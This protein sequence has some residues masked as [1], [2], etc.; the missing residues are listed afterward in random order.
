[1]V[2]VTRHSITL[3]PALSRRERE[4]YVALL[5]SHSINPVTLLV[6]IRRGRK[7]ST[8]IT[9]NITSGRELLC[10]VLLM[11]IGLIKKGCDPFILSP[12][13]LYDPINDF[14]ENILV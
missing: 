3:T 12:V 2:E 7:F 11:Q 9:R 5:L 8:L 10:S 6:E 14:S 13:F 1:H 4:L